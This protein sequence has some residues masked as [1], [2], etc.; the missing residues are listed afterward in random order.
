[1]YF[2][3]Y[4]YVFFGFSHFQG[5]NLSSIERINV[6]KNAQFETVYIN[7]QITLSSLGCAQYHSEFDQGSKQKGI[8]LLGGFDGEKYVENSLV[9]TPDNMKI[10]ECDVII[11]NFSKHFQFLFH[12]ESNFIQMDNN[13][14][15]VQFVFDMK[16]NVNIITKDSYELLSEV[17]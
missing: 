4:I 5:K 6:D 9:F 14:N 17:Q 12:Q 11:P 2:N 7:E 15:S 16:N 10:R 8:L 1:M 3:D 13:F